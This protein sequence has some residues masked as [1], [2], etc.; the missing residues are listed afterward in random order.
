MKYTIEGFSQA[1][2]LT[3]RKE[4]EQRGKIVTK[5][6]D[7][8]DLVILRWFVDFYPNMKKVTVDGEQ[9]A[10]LTHKKLMEDLPLIDI[11]KRAFMERMQKLVDFQILTY[12]LL[13]EGGTF[14]LYGFGKNYANLVRSNNEG[15]VVQTT[16]G[17]QNEP[18]G[19]CRSNDIGYVAQTANKDNSIINP[20]IKDTSIEIEK[21]ERKEG[22][23]TYDEIISSMIDNEDVKNTL[24]E[25]IKMRKFIKKP[26]TDFALKKLINKLNKLSTE[27]A[28][29]ISILE[30]S[31]LNSWQDIYPP[32]ENKTDG[33]NNDIET[34]NNDLQGKY[35]NVCLSLDEYNR[36][37]DIVQKRDGVGLLAALDTVEKAI[38]FLSDYMHNNPTKKYSSHY[39]AINDW[40]FTALKERELKQEELEVKE[41]ELEIRRER[42]KI[43]SAAL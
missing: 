11:N 13:Q 25:F 28:E 35:M 21:K 15:R 4:V 16:Q 17:E 12:R 43:K 2:A 38:D 36:L 19:V 7:C 31:I 8:T 24:Y 1:Y 26:M 14:S 39:K 42:I 33:S 40:V 37:A 30:T 6:I 3:L 10:W 20:S 22:S 27:P 18:Q 32:K 23:L 41:Q 29:Q 34:N 9:F 5:K